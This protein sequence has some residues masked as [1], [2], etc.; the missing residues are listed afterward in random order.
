MN[1]TMS[2][3]GTAVAAVSRLEYLQKRMERNGA[4][5]EVTRLRNINQSIKKASGL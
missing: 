5:P 3:N 1:G 2:A 4:T